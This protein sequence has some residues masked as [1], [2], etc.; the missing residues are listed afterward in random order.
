MPANLDPLEKESQIEETTGLCLSGGGYRA[1]IFHLGTLI[2]LNETGHLR[3]LARVSS[4]SGGS[5]TSAV[6]GLHWKDLKWDS[7]GRAENLIEKVVDPV[8]ALAR[9][10]IDEGAVIGGLFDPFHSVGDKVASAYNKALFSG[11]TL[12]ALPN[13]SKGEGPRFIIN[14]TNIQSGVLWRFSR[15]YMGDYKVGLVKDPTVPLAV[16]VAASSAFPP[17]LSP[18]RLDASH[19]T[20]EPGTGSSL[21]RTPFIEKVMLSDGGVYDNMGMETVWKRCRTVLVSDAGA[22]LPAEEEPASDWARHSI[23]VLNIVDNQV[24][25]L[26][27]RELIAAFKAGTEHKGAYWSIRNVPADYPAV[28]SVAALGFDPARAAALAATPTRLKAMD[29]SWQEG[30]INLGYVTTA[31]A[32]ASHSPGPLASASVA[33]PYARGI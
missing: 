13:D 2:R 33:W 14:A 29:D 11:A 19:F 23:R 8:R 22:A 5:I 18:V 24:R 12:Q 25:S 9:T 15:P 32:L 30:L 17:I 6:L 7:Q 21:Q 26:R 31:V 27:K 28:A 3:Q 16:A 20:F 1:T 10:T 4:V